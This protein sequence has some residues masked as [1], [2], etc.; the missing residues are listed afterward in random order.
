[1]AILTCD[2]MDCGELDR[3]GGFWEDDLLY[4]LL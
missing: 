4:C 3:S 2:V 1:M